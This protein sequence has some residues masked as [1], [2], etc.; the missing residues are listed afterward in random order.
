MTNT[1]RP[2]PVTYA[3]WLM[4]AGAALSVVGGVVGMAAA[5]SL[6]AAE[7]S[8]FHQSLAGQ[9]QAALPSLDLLTRFFAAAM[10]AGGVIDALLWLWMAWKNGQ[11][12]S[13]ARVLSTVFF[14]FLCLGTI[15]SVVRV[16]GAEI[17]SLL[18]GLVNFA[19]GLTV[20]ILLYRPE[21]SQYIQAVK[22][23]RL[24]GYPPVPGPG[25]YYGYGTPQ[26]TYGYGGYPPPPPNPEDPPYPPSPND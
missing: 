22:M 14:G 11:G 24:G 20:I 10:V 18:L 2:Q 3:V 15:S 1:P 17:G 7:L 8:M 19:V 12:R 13:W 9:P 26:S 5:R 23:E 4:Y 6:A 21:S 16:S 25:G